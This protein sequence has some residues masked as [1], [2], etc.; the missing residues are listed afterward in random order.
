EGRLAGV[1]QADEADVG[2]QFEAQPDPHLLAGRAGLVLA[3]G[4][5]G[6]RLVARVAAA[7]DAALK[8]GDALALFGEVGEEGAL[9]V[10]GEELR[11]DR[12]P[13]DEVVAPGAGPVGAGAAF[14]A[15]RAEML[16]VAE[17]DQRI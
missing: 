17:V 3:R 9:L 16:G 7:A 4:A 2:E 12:D 5:V 14:A 13:N 15:R 6:R 1:G 8:Q 11:A 10:V